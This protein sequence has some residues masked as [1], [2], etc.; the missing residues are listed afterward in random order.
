[1]TY[2]INGNREWGLYSNQKNADPK[3]STWFR[4]AFPLTW[5]VNH[6]PKAPPVDFTDT[7][8]HIYIEV[9]VEVVFKTVLAYLKHFLE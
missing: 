8:T 3:T 7:L 6:E 2:P 4:F 5:F 9:A 1:M